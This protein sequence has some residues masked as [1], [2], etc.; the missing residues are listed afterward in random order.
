MEGL[1]NCSKC[2]KVNE[3]CGQEQ[4]LKCLANSECE[5]CDWPRYSYPYGKDESRHCMHCGA[6][7][8]VWK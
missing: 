8:P 4:V 3:E 5:Y 6:E 1:K 7:W 2:E